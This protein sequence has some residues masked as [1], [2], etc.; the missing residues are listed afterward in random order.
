MILPTNWMERESGPR[1]GFSSFHNQECMKSER[2]KKHS[3]A[4]LLYGK[5]RVD[6]FSSQIPSST[7]IRFSVC[8]IELTDKTQ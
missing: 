1:E 3:T 4:L 5:T 8:T 7:P 2:L 6:D